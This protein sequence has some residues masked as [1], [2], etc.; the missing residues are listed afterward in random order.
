MFSKK[1]SIGNS[2]KKKIPPH[3][4]YWAIIFAAF[5]VF[6]L[7]V[8]TL[9]NFSGIQ[10][11]TSKD[12]SS[13]DQLIPFTMLDA[14]LIF[15]TIVEIDNQQLTMVGIY[16][17]KYSAL[18]TSSLND[19]YAVKCDDQTLVTRFG[20]VMDTA[21]EQVVSFEDISVGNIVF[22]YLE[23]EIGSEILQ[24][25]KVQINVI[26]SIMGNIT[27]ISENEITLNVPY[28]S[29]PATNNLSYQTYTIIIGKNTSFYFRE[30]VNLSNPTAKLNITDGELRPATVQ[31]I[32]SSSELIVYG[33]EPIYNNKKPVLAEKIYIVQ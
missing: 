6:L 27:N 33:E 10:Q 13:K 7:I 2:L 17:E 3:T 21:N 23:N 28:I 24:A 1:E 20:A 14:P 25:K 19:R 12:S 11:D 32:R 31:D 16:A 18:N 4:A 30:R 5:V 9:D 8:S 29:D 15:G 22:I 26:S